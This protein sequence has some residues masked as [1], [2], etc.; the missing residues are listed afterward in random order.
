MWRLLEGG[1]YWRLFRRP[2][3][4]GGIYLSVAFISGRRLME[5]IQYATS[6]LLAAAAVAMS[7]TGIEFR[8]P[9]CNTVKSG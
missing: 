6:G 3:C 8:V 7:I 4:W 2:C 9:S 1:M 5:L